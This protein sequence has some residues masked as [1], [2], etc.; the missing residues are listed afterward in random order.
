MGLEI[1]VGNSLALIIQLILYD[2]IKKG[3][4]SDPKLEKI[5]YAIIKRME[6]F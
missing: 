1:V 4:L 5:R 6:D 2:R 3:L